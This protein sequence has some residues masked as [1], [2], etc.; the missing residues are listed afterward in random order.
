MVGTYLRAFTWLTHEE[1]LELERLTEEKPQAREAQRALARSVTALVHGEAEVERVEAASRAL[2][3]RGELGELDAA[4]LDA[5]LAEVPTARV[6]RADSPTIVDL[7]VASG[8]STG[9]G[10]ARRTVAEG[11]AY[12]NNT[13]VGAEDWTPADADLLHGRW[14]VVRRGKRTT[15]GVELVSGG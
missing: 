13:K 5:A 6:P 2:F 12:V 14:L 4:T 8:L 7:L 11:G 3:G 1:I 10:A 9:R 15:A